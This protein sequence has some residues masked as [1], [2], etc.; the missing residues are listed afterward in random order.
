MPRLCKFLSVK[1]L[2]LDKVHVDAMVVV[3]EIEGLKSPLLDVTGQV[4]NHFLISMHRPSGDSTNSCG[5]DKIPPYTPPPMLSPMRLGSG[6]YCTTPVTPSLKPLYRQGIQDKYMA[7]A[8]HC[9]I[10]V[11]Y[12]GVNFI[13]RECRT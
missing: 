11:T 7:I 10:S 13:F 6:L 1:V 12:L 5:N 8:S 4:M 3:L 9:Y 2:S